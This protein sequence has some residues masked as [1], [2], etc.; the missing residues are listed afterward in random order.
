MRAVVF[1]DMVVVAQ[2][3]DLYFLLNR[4]DF[5]QAAG[6]EYFDGV[7]VAGALVEGLGDGAIGALAE[8]IQQLVLL[9]RV[10]GLCFR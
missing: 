10:R 1:D 3:Q 4:V 7:E 2:L 9:F 8:D 5:G 6:R